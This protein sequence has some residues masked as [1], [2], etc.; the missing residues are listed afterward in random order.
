[1]GNKLHIESCKSIEIERAHRLRTKS[2]SNTKPI[3]VKFAAYQDK[4][5]ILEQ[6]REQMR[7]DKE[8]RV[9]EDFTQRVRWIRS[10][11]YPFLKDARDKG[12]TSCLSYDKLVIDGKVNSYDET[13]DD[14]RQVGRRWTSGPRRSSPSLAGNAPQRPQDKRESEELGTDTEAETDT[15]K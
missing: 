14:I 9:S 2:S 12:L 3:I 4:A 5:N 6:A 8:V 10:Q 11:L 15:A 7:G 13:E 1:M